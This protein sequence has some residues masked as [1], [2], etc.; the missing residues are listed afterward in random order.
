[1][2]A[3]A[4]S[5]IRCSV[6]ILTFNSAK[7]LRRA[8]ESVK[9]FSDIIISDGGSTDETL[10][11][12]SAYGATVIEQ[13]AK[14]KP[15]PEPRHPITDFAAERN[16]MLKATK[17]RW[18]L[19]I[20]SDEYLSPQLRDEIATAVTL[21][22]GF[23]GYNLPMVLQDQSGAISYQLPEAIYQVRLINLAVGGSFFRA[24]HER[25]LFDH[26]LRP[27]I[28]TLSGAWYVPISKPD[29]PTYRWAVNYRL[30]LLHKDFPPQNFRA[31]LQRAWFKPF[32]NTIGIFKRIITSYLFVPWKQAL[33][34]YYFRNRL[35]SQ[36]V[37]FKVVTQLYWHSSKHE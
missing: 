23:H 19:W 37:T 21:T 26:N 2:D 14:T 33:P 17:E 5:K 25:F 29:F 32:L 16:Q 31:Y 28:G 11:I 13:I 34:L 20:D 15:G 24:I 12:A 10:A 22:E 3:L 18:F 7:T 30:R 1:M 35:Y 36:W 27:K 6:G 4:S 8:L 9:D